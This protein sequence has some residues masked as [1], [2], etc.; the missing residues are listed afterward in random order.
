MPQVSIGYGS[1]LYMVDYSQS[2]TALV[3]LAEILEITPPNQQDDLIEATHMQSPNR[4]KEYILGLTEPGETAFV[5]HHVPGSASEDLIFANRARARQVPP[6]SSTCRLVFPNGVYWE[7]EALPRGYEPSTPINDRM[8]V[9]VT[10]QVTGST[11]IGMET[12]A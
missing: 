10:M 9:S 5:M 8:T 4:T 7:F 3:E 12:P 2:P 1:K 6:L 11:A